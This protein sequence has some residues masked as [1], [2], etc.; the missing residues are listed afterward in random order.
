MCSI[1]GHVYSLVNEMHNNYSYSFPRVSISS[2]SKMP[3]VS[4]SQSHTELDTQRG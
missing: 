4:L 3:K 1:F 2:Q